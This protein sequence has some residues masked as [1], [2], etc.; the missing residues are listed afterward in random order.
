VHRIERKEKRRL[1]L[2]GFIDAELVDAVPAREE[3]GVDA[4]DK[5][6]E[7]LP[8]DLWIDRRAK[9]HELSDGDARK[10]AVG[11]RVGREIR[12]VEAEEAMQHR[13]PRA[14]IANH[15]D[16]RVDILLAPL[17]EE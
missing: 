14:R 2:L 7:R 12:R 10:E 16:G 9:A 6:P 11:E 5:A 17:G 3:D 15:K 4:V 13:R 1:I 8:R